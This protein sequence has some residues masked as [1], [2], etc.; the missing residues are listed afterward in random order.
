MWLS[1]QIISYVVR[2]R[3]GNISAVSGHGQ[4]EKVSDISINCL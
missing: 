1:V 2:K 3:V 4:K